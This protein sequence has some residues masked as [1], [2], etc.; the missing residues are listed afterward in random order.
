MIFCIHKEGRQSEKT[1]DVGFY[2]FK[3]VTR[4]KKL[5][6]VITRKRNKRMD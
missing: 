5:D 1:F 3:K 6:M 4:F 2:K